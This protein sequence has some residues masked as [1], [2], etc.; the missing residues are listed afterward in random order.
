[1]FCMSL[2][3][4]FRSF[5]K[6][7]MILGN[8]LKVSLKKYSNSRAV[9][10]IQINQTIRLSRTYMLHEINWHGRVFLITTSD[11]ELK[12]LHSNNA[13]ETPIASNV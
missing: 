6:I 10:S 4:K 8:F 2:F 12:V 7:K 5:G 1:M 13:D 11:S 3:L 9:N